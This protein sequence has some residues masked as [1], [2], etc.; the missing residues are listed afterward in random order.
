MLEYL[1][2][3]AEGLNDPAIEMLY[4]VFVLLLNECLNM[5]LL[6]KATKLRKRVFFFLKNDY[7]DSV[8][9]LSSD[10]RVFNILQSCHMHLNRDF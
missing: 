3:V 1:A 8:R 9:D 2:M 4:I 5:S 6:V 10:M 7:S